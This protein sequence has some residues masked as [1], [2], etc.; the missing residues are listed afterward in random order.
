MKVAFEADQDLFAMAILP[1]DKELGG[2][3]WMELG[4]VLCCLSGIFMNRFWVLGWEIGL[5][6]DIEVRGQGL[7][8]GTGWCWGCR[9]PRPR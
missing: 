3:G 9:A 1:T 4:F 2:Y 6:W 5:R 8:C 7:G